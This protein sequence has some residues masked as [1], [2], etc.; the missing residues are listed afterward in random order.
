MAKKPQNASSEPFADA[1]V[2]EMKKLVSFWRLV[3]E[4]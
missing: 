3:Q 4:R 2:V 1:K